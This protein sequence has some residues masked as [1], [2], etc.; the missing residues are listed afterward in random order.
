MNIRLLCTD[1]GCYGRIEPDWM[2]THG[3]WMRQG[4][5]ELVCEWCGLCHKFLFTAEMLE[6]EV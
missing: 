4:E 6:A 1:D 3:V 2:M 5:F